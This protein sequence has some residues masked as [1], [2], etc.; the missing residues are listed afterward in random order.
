MV[1]WATVMHGGMLVNQSGHRFGNE[2]VG[3]SEYAREVLKQPGGVAWVVIDTRIDGLCRA[4]ADYSDLVDHDGIKWCDSVDDAAS[5]IGA[6][7]HVLS[8]TLA[9]PH[10]VAT[11]HPDAFGRTF[12]EAE[13]QPPF[14]VIKVTGALFHT[15][16][17]L[18]TDADGAVLKH[19]TVIPG[20]FAAG[21]AAAGISGHGPDGYIAGNGLLAAL[22]LGYRAGRAVN[23]VRAGVA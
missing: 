5:W 10:N 16:G 1:T 15:Q 18:L 20:L 6:D 9:T 22:G 3:Y 11:G 13:V 21:G 17:G 7:A 4:F 23:R 2:T 12:W 14:G 19:G 8:D